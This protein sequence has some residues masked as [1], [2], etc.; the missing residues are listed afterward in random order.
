MGLHSCFTCFCLSLECVVHK[1]I[2]ILCPK[3]CFYTSK[4]FPSL[5][6]LP[7]RIHAPTQ[8][9]RSLTGRSGGA[10][11][12]RLHFFT[13]STAIMNIKNEF[14][15]TGV[16]SLYS[17]LGYCKNNSKAMF[18]H[19]LAKRFPFGFAAIDGIQERLTAR[20]RAAE[21]EDSRRPLC[22]RAVAKS[23]GTSADHSLP[24]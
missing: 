20:E 11:S 18:S 12:G 22:S 3:A 8:R 21:A 7:G 10:L 1:F 9:A 13:F 24:K 4:D 17:K 19:G 23:L 16:L 6:V 14:L 5:A 2:Q 15:E